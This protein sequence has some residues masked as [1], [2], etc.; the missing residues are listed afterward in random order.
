M[1]CKRNGPNRW[2]SLLIRGARRVARGV[3]RAACGS[4]GWVEPVALPLTACRLPLG[5]DAGLAAALERDDIVVTDAI[6]FHS[7]RARDHSRN[8]EAKCRGFFGDEFLD[9]VGRNV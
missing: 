2:E 6:A 3:W 8:G 7:R 5:V 4:N 1:I 9:D